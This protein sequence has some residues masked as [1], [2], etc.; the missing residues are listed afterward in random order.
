MK[1]STTDDRARQIEDA[2]KNLPRV[3]RRNR[4]SRIR[5]VRVHREKTKRLSDHDADDER[6]NERTNEYLPVINRTSAETE[7]TCR[8]R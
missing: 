7:R 1:R 2:E 4:E 8:P 5:G 3:T 6:M